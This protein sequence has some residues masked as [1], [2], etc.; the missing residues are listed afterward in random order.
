MDK[1]SCPCGSGL[2]FQACCGRFLEQKQL[3]ST[4]QALMRSR[5]TA[6]VR[7]DAKYLYRSW[8]QQTRPS[9]QSLKA[10]PPVDW[11]G[12]EIVNSEAGGVN[13]TEGKVEFMARYMEQGRLYVMQEV[14][15]F[16][17]E[18]G[19]WVYMEGVVGSEV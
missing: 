4:A 14:S 8:D 6:Y 3:P 13:D 17:R 2:D 15:F 5:Y 16:R 18:K 1:S 19:R 10:M 7:G 12:L 9:F 11:I